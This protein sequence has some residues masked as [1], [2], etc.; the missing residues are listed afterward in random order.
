[1][2]YWKAAHLWSVAFRFIDQ[3]VCR[4]PADA[5]SS[6]G[7]EADEPIVGPLDDVSDVEEQAAEWYMGYGVANMQEQEDDDD[8]DYLR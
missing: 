8:D 6:C 2:E 3:C 7:S 5:S 4:L 1:V